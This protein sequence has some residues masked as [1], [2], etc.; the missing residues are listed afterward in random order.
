[1]FGAAACVDV[2]RQEGLGFKAHTARGDVVRLHIEVKKK[3]KKGMMQDRFVI[4]LFLYFLQYKDG[5][6][7]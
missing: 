2:R 1:M 6:K 5:G 4:V 7:A 3:R